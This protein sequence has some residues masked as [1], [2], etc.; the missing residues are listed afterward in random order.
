MAD[1]ECIRL[2]YDFWREKVLQRIP[3]KKKAEILAPAE[4]PHPFRAKRT[5]LEQNYYEELSRPNV[6][7][8]SLNGNPIVEFISEGIVTADGVVHKADIV[9]LATG[10]DAVTNPLRNI[11]ITSLDNQVLEDKWEFGTYTYMGVSTAG[12][13][14]FFFPYGPQSPTAFSNGPTC[15]EAQCHWLTDILTSLRGKG[16]TRIMPTKAAELDWKEK[17]NSFSEK[18]LWHKLDS[19]YVY[20]VTSHVVHPKLTSFQVHGHQYSREAKRGVEFRGRAA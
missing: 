15:I 19:W 5:S 4:L 6:H 3:D 10:F 18:T 2:A 12:F 1:G 17:V 11:T 14:K 16:I 9:A 20:R 8:I 7:V 13:P